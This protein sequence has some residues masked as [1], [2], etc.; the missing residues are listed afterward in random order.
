MAEWSKAADCKSVGKY[1]RWFES[2]SSH[3]L[4]KKI[5]KSYILRSL[6][7][8]FVFIRQ[9]AKFI[10]SGNSDTISTTVNSSLRSNLGVD[11]SLRSNLG[12][13]LS[14]S[15]TIIIYNTIISALVKVFVVKN[16]Y[17]GVC[18]TDYNDIMDALDKVTSSA[19]SDSTNID[20]LVTIYDDIIASCI[21]S[22]NNSGVIN[23]DNN[24]IIGVICTIY[25]INGA[26]NDIDIVNDT[27]NSVNRGSMSSGVNTNVS[28]ATVSINT[29]IDIVNNIINHVNA[30]NDINKIIANVTT[31][32]KKVTAVAYDGGVLRTSTHHLKNKNK[33]Y[34]KIHSS[35][36]RPY[37]SNKI[38]FKRS[39]NYYLNLNFKRIRFFPFLKKDGKTQVFFNNSLGMISKF[40]SK[41]KAFLRQKTSYLLSAAFLRKIML[42]TGLKRLILKIKGVP[43]FL[44]DIISVILNPNKKTYDHPFRSPTHLVDENTLAHGFT[45]NYVLFTNLK[46]HSLMKKKKKGRLK[47]KVAKKIVLLNNILD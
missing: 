29:N 42:Y 19:I 12:V 31:I 26:S 22:C 38:D 16:V 6:D 4:T 30:D 18:I 44:R 28:N 9:N 17:G 15:D 13:D 39:D 35:T 27:I 7:K 3:N 40:F 11:L 47:R 36:L 2:N 45:F 46:P 32:S 41:T 8:K 37:L 23:I 34:D 43:L 21:Y 20:A 24:T 5:R 10:D 14:K 33:L 25:N 1:R